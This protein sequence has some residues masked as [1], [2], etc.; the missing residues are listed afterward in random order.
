LFELCITFVLIKAQNIGLTRDPQ[1]S[2]G[3]RPNL[4]QVVIND[5]LQKDKELVFSIP[6]SFQ[7]SSG[8]FIEDTGHLAFESTIPLTLDI[9]L[10]GTDPVNEVLIQNLLSDNPACKTL[11]E[12]ATSESRPFTS[13]GPVPVTTVI[14]DKVEH[15]RWIM[16]HHIECLAS[17][18]AT[19]NLAAA[20]FEIE[21]IDPTRPDDR[22][23]EYL[24]NSLSTLKQLAQ[25]QAIIDLIRD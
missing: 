13:Y 16:L 6:H 25:D 17:I 19:Q 10:G 11:E 8:A 3:N 20:L 24:L 15:Q 21:N 2:P 18:I 5:L 22:H 1:F 9:D 14:A 4:Y 12:Y 7:F 23:T